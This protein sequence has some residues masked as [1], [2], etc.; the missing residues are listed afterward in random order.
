M[1]EKIHIV[2][3]HDGRSTWYADEAA[4]KQALSDLRWETRGRRVYQPSY[5]GAYGG[6][7]GDEGEA[8]AIS[9]YEELC[10]AVRA[11]WICYP[12]ARCVARLEWEPAESCW[13]WTMNR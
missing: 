8:E 7:K 13:I 2:A 12:D 5:S 3:V 9:E 6:T 1:S 10:D 4:L 11:M